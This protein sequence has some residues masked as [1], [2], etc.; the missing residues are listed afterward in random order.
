MFVEA[1]H[2]TLKQVYMQ[3]KVNRRVDKCL[4]VLLRLA[5]DK[6][7][8]RLIK[9]EK[10]KTSSRLS[11]I[12][13]RHMASLELSSECVHVHILR[14]KV[15]ITLT[16]IQ[17]SLT[18]H[19]CVSAGGSSIWAVKSGDAEY[20]VCQENERCTQGCA[21]E[22]THCNICLHM[23]SC[24]C[25]DHLIHSTICKHIHLVVRTSGRTVDSHPPSTSTK[26]D[27]QLILDAVRQ[28]PPPPS[29]S[30]RSRLLS[31]LDE[32]RACAI[33]CSSAEALLAV[34]KQVT[35]AISVLKALT[36]QDISA[37]PQAPIEPSNK[38]MAIQRFKSMKKR[39]KSTKVLT[40]TQPCN[41][42]HTYVLYV[43]NVSYNN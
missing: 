32:L 7:F 10:G 3:G 11:A 38:K 21:L 39:R 6:A 17:Y 18:C 22:C 31:K 13:A 9:L 41:T 28:P 19:S 2:N 36:S 26:D 37:L 29:T 40:L 8:E 34:E 43:Y 16:C 24:T 30:G 20:T 35:A 14:T 27:T 15:H 1:F 5:R 42:V 23:F 25:H 33:E 4:H 12:H